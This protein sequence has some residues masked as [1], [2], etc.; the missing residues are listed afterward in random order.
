MRRK[1]KPVKGRDRRCPK[2][3]K[4]RYRDHASANIAIT[5]IA[6]RNDDERRKRPVRA[7]YCES[8]KGWHL[9]S[10]PAR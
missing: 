10:L 8:C 9:T 6:L 7:Y 5:T 3:G 1:T 2:T 4:A